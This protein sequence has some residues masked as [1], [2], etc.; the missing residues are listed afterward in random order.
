[1]IFPSGIS[2]LWLILPLGHDAHQTDGGFVFRRH[3]SLVT[4]S[5]LIELRAS[6]RVI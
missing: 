6:S 4:L 2:I 3:K 1:L 5:R